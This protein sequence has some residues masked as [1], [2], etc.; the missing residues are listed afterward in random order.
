[1]IDFFQ[2][3]CQGIAPPK[4]VKVRQLEQ[5]PFTHSGT[6]Y[7][8]TTASFHLTV[9][10]LRNIDARVCTN[11]QA[12]PH[13]NF[14]VKDKDIRSGDFV[15]SKLLRKSNVQFNAMYWALWNK[16]LPSLGDV[17]SIIREDVRDGDGADKFARK[18]L[19]IAL[20]ADAEGEVDHYENRQILCPQIIGLVD[21]LLC[22]S[23]YGNVE[24]LKERCPEKDRVPMFE[25]AGKRAYK[26]RDQFLE[27]WKEHMF[28]NGSKNGEES[29]NGKSTYESDD[30]E[31]DSVSAD[32]DEDG[33]HA[34]SGMTA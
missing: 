10:S 12:G 33:S 21:Q 3:P 23:C 32:E 7:N 30:D 16:I 5:Y 31:E 25:G 18:T 29:V 28:S 27:A 2:R 24:M 17:H 34:R 19:K 8:A 1:M 11:S 13:V 9:T 22:V 4:G 26:V 6:M 14:F 20:T 15:V